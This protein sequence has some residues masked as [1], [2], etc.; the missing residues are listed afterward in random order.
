MR[1]VSVCALVA[2]ALAGPALAGQ[3]NEKVDKF[4]GTRTVSWESFKDPGR[5]YSLNVYA[6]FAKSYNAKPFGYYALLVPPHGTASFADCHQ[7]DWLI[8]GA[9]TP[10]LASAYR[11][12]GNSQMFRVELGRSTLEKIA[13]AKSVEVKICNTEAEISAADIAGVRQLLHATE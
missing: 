9:P 12:S 10:E 8:D 13:S 11:A 1:F 5:G 4:K 6:H 2:C 3:L 7:N